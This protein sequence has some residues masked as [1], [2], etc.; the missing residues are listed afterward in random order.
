MEKKDVENKKLNYIIFVF[1]IVK[2]ICLILIALFIIILV[3]RIIRFINY[4]EEPIN[5][6]L[7]SISKIVSQFN[8]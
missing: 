2:V 6:G 5:N 8:I 7:I 4:I 3:L 1:E